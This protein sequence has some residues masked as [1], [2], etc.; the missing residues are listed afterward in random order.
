MHVGRLHFRLAARQ[1]ASALARFDAAACY[2]RLSEL[3]RSLDGERWMVV[4]GLVEPL[5]NGRF[6]R[7]HSDIDIAVPV[8][9]LRTM[10][11]A[12]DR[13]G[14]AL[15]TRVLRTHVSAR[16]DLEAHLVVE[17]WML[18]HRCR[19]LRLWR[20]TPR[21]DLDESTFPPYVDVFPYELVG[22][23][24]HILDSGQRL[25]LRAPLWR[26]VALPDGASVPVEDPSYVEALKAARRLARLRDATRGAPGSA[27]ASP[28]EP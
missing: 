12:V 20:L 19:R 14:Y 3:A 5:V 8:G 1:R 2:A 21:G 11:E 18:A 7:A 17:P 4:S 24:L 16:A 26:D 10:A 25:P 28:L 23:Q 27:A 6:V 9:S 13:Y 22:R 15:T